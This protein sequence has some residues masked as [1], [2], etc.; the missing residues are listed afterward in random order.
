MTCI[1]HVIRIHP[2]NGKSRCLFLSSPFSLSFIFKLQIVP[3]SDCTYIVQLSYKN[4][5]ILTKVLKELDVQ[6]GL[7]RKSREN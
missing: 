1:Q 7:I 6:M 3:N 2:I 4:L 5:E